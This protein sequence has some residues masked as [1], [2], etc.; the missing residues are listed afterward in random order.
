MSDF[1]NTCINSFN[2]TTLKDNQELNMKKIFK[3]KILTI[4]LSLIFTVESA[5]AATQT[6]ASHVI[7]RIQV[8]EG[9]GTFF[10]PVGP[11]GTGLQF[12]GGTGACPNAWYATL[13][14]DSEAYDEIY[15]LALASKLTETPIYFVGDC[16]DDG[17]HI[18]ITYAF[19]S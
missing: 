10:R 2:K 4:L 9:G 14:T 18:F 13:S 3:M 19:F 5:Q 6:S 17:K 8:Q 7:G 16:S 12:W 11:T 1:S 15:A